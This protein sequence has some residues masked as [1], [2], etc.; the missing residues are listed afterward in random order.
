MLS[1]SKKVDYAL[2]M[3]AS[4]PD[5][6]SEEFRSLQDIAAEKHLSAGFLGQLMMPL[7]KSGLVSSREG[8][9]GGYQLSRPSQDISLNDIYTALEGPLKLTACLDAESSCAC[10]K[11]CPTKTVWSD[12]QELMNNYLS[13]KSLSDFR[14]L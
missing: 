9:K 12:L 4:L 13:H 8:V 14:T 3:M 1:A 2:L 10:E 7:K 6:G 5:Q 11:A